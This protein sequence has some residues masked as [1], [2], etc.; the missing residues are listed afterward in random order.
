MHEPAEF[1]ADSAYDTPPS[2]YAIDVESIDD[3]KAH[4]SP[5]PPSS[6]SSTSTTTTT[7]STTSSGG[8]TTGTAASQPMNLSTIYLICLILT[9]CSIFFWLFQIVPM[10][11]YLVFQKNINGPHNESEASLLKGTWIATIIIAVVLLVLILIYAV[12]TWGFG[13][14]L[15]IFLIPYVICIILLQRA[16]SSMT[17][18]SS[19]SP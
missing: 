17:I 19:P 12:L 8:G 15:L 3:D 4:R 13:L 10:V 1:A 2:M 9:I 14:I 7:T 6:S 11:L 18:S 5:P 16:M